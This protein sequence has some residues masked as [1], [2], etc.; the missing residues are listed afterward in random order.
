MPGFGR[1]G[2]AHQQ[3]WFNFKADFQYAGL[4]AINNRRADISARNGGRCPPNQRFNI[5][6]DF[7]YAGFGATNNRRADISA[8]NGGRCPIAGTAGF[9][10]DGY[11]P[12]GAS[13]A[14][15]KAS[16]RQQVLHR[17][18][19]VQPASRRS[20]AAHREVYSVK[21]VAFLLRNI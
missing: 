8:H 12:V 2:I 4:G 16:L 21:T 14:G 20:G 7:Q 18:Y 10:E 9:C 1:V 17:V 5:K 3:R 13:R 11:V 15:E 19:W 6:A